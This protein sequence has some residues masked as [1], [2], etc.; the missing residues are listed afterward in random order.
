MQRV[1]EYNERGSGEPWYKIILMQASRKEMAI[2]ALVLVILTAMSVAR[3][4][5]GE[6]FVWQD[7]A[8]IGTPDFWH[9]AFW[10]ALTFMTLG[11]ILY[12]IRFYQVLSWMLGSDR[13]GYRQM[14]GTIWL[15]LMFLNYQILPVIVDCMNTII[16]IAY[17]SFMLAIYSAPMLLAGLMLG[18]LIGLLME[19]KQI[20]ELSRMRAGLN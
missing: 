9:R 7:I 2:V 19:R 13:E 4:F 1:G 20:I 18:I 16:S 3:L 15:G 10:S 6:S 11:A 14:K 5:L 12:A 8:P 17:N